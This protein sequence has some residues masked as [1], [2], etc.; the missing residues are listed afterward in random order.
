[1]PTQEIQNNFFHLTVSPEEG[2]FSLHSKRVG[3]LS[4]ENGHVKVRIIKSNKSIQILN[5]AWQPYQLMKTTADSIHGRLTQLEFSVFIEEYSQIVRLTFALSDEF[6][7]FLWKAIIENQSSSPV[8]VDKIELINLGNSKDSKSLLNSGAEANKP[9]YAF[10]SNGWQSWSFSGTFSENQ[11]QKHT[12]LKFF[13]DVLVQNAGTPATRKPGIFSSDFFGVIA[14]RNARTACLFGF[15]SQKQHYGSIETELKEHLKIKMWANGDLTRLD[16]GYNMETDWAIYYPYYF[17][18]PDALKIYYDAVAREHEISLPENMPTGWC[19]WYHFYQ[20]ISEQV[21]SDNLKSIIQYQLELP[22]DLVQIDD[23]FEKEVG[24]WF[25]FRKGFP[26]GV[27][28]LAEEIKSAGLTPGLWL[29]PFILHP[30][31][32]YAIMNPDKI[33]RTRNNQ[34]VNAGYIWNVF[35]QALDLSNPEAMEYVLKI[36]DKAAN[37][38]GFP[39]LKLDFLYAGALMGNRF[40]KTR[41]RAQIMRTA[42][43]AIRDKV[44]KDTFLLACGAPLGSVLGLVEANRIGPDVSG[45]WTPKYFGTTFFFEKERSMPSARNSIQNI[46]TRAEMHGRWWINDPDCLLVRSN[47]NLKLA[48]VQSLASAIAITGGSLLI[49]DDLPTLKPERRKIAEV[50]IPVI[51]KRAFVMDWLDTTTP[52]NLRLD[53]NN[54]TGEWQ[55]LARFNW[56]ENTR[57]LFVSFPDFCMPKLD[58]WAFSF[59]DQHL[60]KVKSG[61]PIQIPGIEAH[62]VALLS[63]RPVSDQPQYLG[64][65]L[66][67]SMGLEVAEWTL[68]KNK[69]IVKFSLPRCVNG[70][71]YLYLPKPPQEALLDQKQISWTEVDA[72]VFQFPIQFDRHALLEIEFKD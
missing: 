43:Q 27:A 5:G 63:L 34:P 1:M 31:S 3:L 2:V 72:H 51:G 68:I 15:L 19:S 24:D 4:F 60:Y 64:S 55:L 58:Y 28:P 57:E 36:V 47:T 33:L 30:N 17:D 16:P 45:D 40:D 41:T 29:A 62:G 38:W 25:D 59:W 56:K 69:L 11:K 14:D 52:H 66:H 48:E 12:R 22:L 13:Q 67:I 50:L 39:Y 46:L 32:D 71:V 7:V 35:T 70:Q 42:M 26:K 21:I 23:G 54:P 8:I 49:S 44:G 9:V 20:N 65:D 6:P 10:H 53:L 18:Q 61:D 37:E